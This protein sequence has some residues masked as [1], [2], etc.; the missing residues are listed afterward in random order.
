MQIS[1]NGDWANVIFG[2][3]ILPR[4]YQHSIDNEGWPSF[5]LDENSADIEA[6][7]ADRE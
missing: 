4:M 1:F 7:Q 3:R 5:Y 2:T 6:A